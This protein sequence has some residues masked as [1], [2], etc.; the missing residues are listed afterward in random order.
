M[1]LFSVSLFGCTL[2]TNRETMMEFNQA[3]DAGDYGR[4]RLLAEYASLNNSDD[5]LLWLIQ[6]GIAAF[7]EQDYAES[8]RLLDQAERLMNA[9]DTA[10]LVARTRLI[11]RSMLSNDNYS[12]F[13]YRYMDAVL[14]NTYKGWAYLGLDNSAAARVE[15]NRAE[16]R[17]RIA[18]NYFNDLIKEQ[19]K[20]IESQDPEVIATLSSRRF[21]SALKNSQLS[22]GQW[23]PYENY[24]N[25]FTSLSTGIFLRQIGTSPSDL[26]RSEFSLAKVTDITGI[27]VSG[28]M[29]QLVNQYGRLPVVVFIESGAVVRLQ[30][31]R[32][33]LPLLVGSNS[34]EYFGVALPYIPQW[35]APEPYISVNGQEA[36]LV[37]DMDRI[38]A[39][40]FDTD[41]PSILAREVIR[42]ISKAL[43]Q[44]EIEQKDDVA[45]SIFAAIQQSATQAD[46][47]SVTIYPQHYEL[48]LIDAGHRGELNIKVG[49][50]HRKVKINGSG[51][52]VVFIKAHSNYASP[53]VITLNF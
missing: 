48:V 36:R 44:N 45:G 27:D 50:I 11:T 43:L 2:A 39:S 42:S 20:N 10:N 7:F 40:E 29:A 38:F 19:E 13:H 8:I 6:G 52:H 25:P 9:F 12:P 30:E 15:F 53:A 49:N 47:R 46:L 33:E 23:A 26:S 14:V 3:I 32:I 31:D 41:Y 4:A 1:A 16:E 21:N 51:Q 28:E 5:R 34:L 17:Q 37:S 24:V 35:K 22:F 18:V